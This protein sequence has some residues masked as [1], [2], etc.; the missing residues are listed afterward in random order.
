LVFEFD[1][2]VPPG[3]TLIFD[4]SDRARLPLAIYRVSAK[5]AQLLDGGTVS[6]AVLQTNPTSRS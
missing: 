4:A 5:T 1:Y 2:E 6:V 3:S